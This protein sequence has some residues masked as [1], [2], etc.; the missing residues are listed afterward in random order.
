MGC[1]PGAGECDDDE[2]PAHRVTLMRSYLLG[3]T[4][5]TQGQWLAV[6][7]SNPSHFS[8]CGS[9]CPVEKVSWLDAVAFANALSKKEGLEACYVVSGETASWPKGAACTGYRLPT[10]AEWEYAARAGKDSRYSGG[11]ELGA[12]GWFSDNPYG[13]THRVAQKQANAWGLFDMSGNVCEWS[14]DWHGAYSASA[15]TDPVGASDGRFRVYRGGSWFDSA[16][17]ARL[18]YRGWVYPGYRYNYL[19]LR[20]ARSIP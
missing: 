2:K 6:M 5:V 19:G 12:V 11:S 8:S 4:E 14:W 9:D 15:L 7:G 13:K 17:Y 16:R 10:E 20:L 1:T 3:E 18:A